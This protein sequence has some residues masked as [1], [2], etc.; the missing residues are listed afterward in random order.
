[1][2]VRGERV[3]SGG[4]GGIEREKGEV[5]GVVRSMS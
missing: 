1:M 2:C 5:V 3:G 4:G